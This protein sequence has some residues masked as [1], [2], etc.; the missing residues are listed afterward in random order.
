MKKVSIPCF[1]NGTEYAV[2]T[3][4]NCDR[5]YKSPKMKNDGEYYTKSRCRIF[6]ELDVQLLGYGNEPV[7]ERTYN[8]THMRKCPYRKEH[9]PRS[10]RKD[11]DKSL[12]I[13]F[14]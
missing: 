11:N 7:S 1:S 9:F 5:C 14:E 13:N 2:W 12:T 6:D 8:V 4:R 10:K 3:E